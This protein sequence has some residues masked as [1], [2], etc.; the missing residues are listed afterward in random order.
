MTYYN[1]YDRR[2]NEVKYRLKESNLALSVSR[3]LHQN[4]LMERYEKAFKSLYG[5]PTKVEYANGWYL[6]T[7]GNNQTLH[8][9]E[10][11]LTRAI[12]VIEATMERQGEEDV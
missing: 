4:R 10:A 11:A 3:L 8:L 9:R 7:R 2:K 1:A 5:L 6:V 12:Y